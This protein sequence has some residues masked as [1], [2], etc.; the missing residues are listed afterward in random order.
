[1]NHWR[2][3]VPRV[4]YKYMRYRDDAVGYVHSMLKDRKVKYSDPTQ[5]NDPFEARPHVRFPDL[6]PRE[7]R[8]VLTDFIQRIRRAG[9]ASRQVR[10]QWDRELAT[11]DLEDL[12]VRFEGAIRDTLAR[13]SRIYCLAGTRRS[14]LMWA[15]YA[16]K[17]AGVCIHLSG[18]VRPMLTVHPVS[19]THEYPFLVPPWDEMDA[20]KF[21]RVCVTT[22]AKEWRYEQEYR[23][24]LSLAPPFSP[25][26]PGVVVSGD[27][28]TLAGGSIWGI[29]I[30]ARMDP[31]ASTQLRSVAK[32]AGLATWGSTTSRPGVSIAI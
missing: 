11:A 6:P 16:D 30:G 17:H 8:K 5:F 2:N 15:H 26:P 12:R 7:L 9:Q 25:M 27:F 10:R 32:D 1:L 4:L 3:S 21:T 24:I 28:V 23:L 19:Y 31:K 29:T 20:L 18:R 13:N 14:L 22:K